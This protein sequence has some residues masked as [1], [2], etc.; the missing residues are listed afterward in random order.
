MNVEDWRCVSSSITGESILLDQFCGNNMQVYLPS[1]VH[2]SLDLNLLSHFTG[3]DTY[4]ISTSPQNQPLEYKFSYSLHGSR[5]QLYRG[6]N[7]EHFFLLPA[8]PADEGYEGYLS[9]AVNRE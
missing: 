4:L 1:P 7:F 9:L 5:R 2:C 3:E 8:G 6:F